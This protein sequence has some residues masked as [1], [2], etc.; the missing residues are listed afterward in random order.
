MRTRSKWVGKAS[1]SIWFSDF[2]QRLPETSEEWRRRNS[3]TGEHWG[4]EHSAK[5]WPSKRESG[6]LVLR[7]IL[8]ISWKG[9]G[10][11]YVCSFLHDFIRQGWDHVL[12][13]YCFL[14]FYVFIH[15]A[16]CLNHFLSLCNVTIR[17]GDTFMC[18]WC[19]GDEGRE[20]GRQGRVHC[21]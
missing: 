21:E 16:T 11:F 12:S 2:I 10:F 17:N 19:W 3:L 18:T 5:P 7:F 20:K 1:L 14:P 8:M 4:H 13:C 6:T 15:L 9:F